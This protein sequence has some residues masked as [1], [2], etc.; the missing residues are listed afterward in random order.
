L[1]NLKQ[2]AAVVAALTVLVGAFFTSLN[3][4]GWP[5]YAAQAAVEVLAEQVQA[6]TEASLIQQLENAFKRGDIVTIRRLCN[7]IQRKY[8]YKPSGCP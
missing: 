3:Y 7:A 5:P 2:I 4:L 6:N 1:K 8:H